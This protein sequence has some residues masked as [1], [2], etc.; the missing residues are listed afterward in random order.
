MRRNRSANPRGSLS[1]ER[2]LQ[3]ALEII[4]REGLAGLSLRKIAAQLDVST[5]SIYRHY[6]S[7]SEIEVDIVDHV[8]GTSAVTEHGEDEWTEWLQVTYARMREVLCAHPGLLSLLDNASFSASFQGSNALSVIE[9]ALDRLQASGLTPKQA[10][11]LFH[12]LTAYMI[13]SVMM[14]DQAA[15]HATAVR[16][17]ESAEHTRL[18][19]LGFEM[20]SPRD[21]P[22]VVALA[23]H[24]AAVWESGEFS[25]DMLRIIESFGSMPGTAGTP[26]T[27][28]T[29]QKQSRHKRKPVRS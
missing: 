8:V 29:P 3:A 19:R 11:Q 23:P 21:Y 24:L 16:A 26:D 12:M 5:M 13:G 22:N 1:R 20:V 6:R 18:R 27:P 2:V 14:M 9:T 4:D 25:A 17:A 15:R 7:K 10:A 28:S